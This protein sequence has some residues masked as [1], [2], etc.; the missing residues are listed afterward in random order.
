MTVTDYKTGKPVEPGSGYGE[1]DRLKM[2]SY[3][4][5]LLFYKLMV[6]HS[7]DYHS[8]TVASG[9]IAFVE[10]N[11]SGDIVSH[12]IGYDSDELARFEKLIA[13]VWQKIMALD[14][15]DTSGYEPTLKGVIQFEEDL[16]SGTI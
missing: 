16:L 4:Q 8:Y 10:P 12:T 9:T 14:L 1:F 15:P 3:R 13:I 6:E 5:Q 11:K 2:H 7:R